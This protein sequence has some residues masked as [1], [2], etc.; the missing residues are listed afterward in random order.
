MA[1]P[2]SSTTPRHSWFKF[3]PSDW[4]GDELLAMCSLGAR[5]LLMELLCLMH[6]ATPYG[7]LLVNGKAPS[8]AEL[9]RLVRSSTVGELRRLKAEL[10]ERGVLSVDGRKIY[11]RRMVRKAQQSATGRDTGKLGGNPKLRPLTV[12][13][14]GS[15]TH[16]V[17]VSDNPQK[18]EARSQ[19]PEKS[20]SSPTDDEI[21]D[22]AREFIEFY[23]GLYPQRRNGVP[24]RRQDALEFPTACSLVS[25][26]PDD[27]LRLMAEIFLRTDHDFAE[28][29][30]RSIGQFAALAEWCDEK[31]RKNGR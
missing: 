25:T 31:L 19:K 15:P 12:P 1:D 10:L 8:D 30:R 27:R 17:L 3:F 11:S 26:W 28:K 7:Y 29:G 21:G 2:E 24:Y 13:V 20:I 16:P 4:K 14:N 5:G 23:A 18:L 9:A 6:R 22:R